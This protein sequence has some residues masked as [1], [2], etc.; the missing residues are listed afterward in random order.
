[1][2]RSRD[3]RVPEDHDDLSAA[4]G[5]GNPSFPSTAAVRWIPVAP[6]ALAWR[7]W[8]GELV[9]YNDV[10]GSTHHL[11]PLGSDV[12]LTLLR[13]P[14]GIDMTALVRDIADRVEIS[15]ELE[16]DDAIG[17]ALAEL[18]ELKLAATGSA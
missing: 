4:L 7:E 11:S 13:H 3:H 6:D 16:L 5:S 17:Q 15:G 18:A 2:D 10:T 1:M 14:T 12:L 8:D 9:V